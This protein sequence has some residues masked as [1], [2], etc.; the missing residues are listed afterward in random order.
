MR[1]HP[2]RLVLGA[3]T[4]PP[5]RVQILPQRAAAYAAKMHCNGALN[6]ALR[7]SRATERFAASR[8]PRLTHLKVDARCDN[9]RADPRFKDLLRRV[10]LAS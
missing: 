5:Q 9:L 6:R 3:G 1:F 10:G 8:R 2:W 7:R 4:A